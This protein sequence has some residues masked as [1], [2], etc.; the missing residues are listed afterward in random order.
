MYL[1]ENESG[2]LA[3]LRTEHCRQLRL[4]AMW[5]SDPVIKEAQLSH[6]FSFENRLTEV[7]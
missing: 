4:L 2:I 6:C 1:G 3:G 5:G 7:Q